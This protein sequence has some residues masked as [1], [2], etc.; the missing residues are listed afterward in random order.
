MI[1]EDVQNIKINNFVSIFNIIYFFNAYDEKKY[2][3]F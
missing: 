3:V 2:S 1:D